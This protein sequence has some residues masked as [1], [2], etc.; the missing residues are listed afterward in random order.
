MESIDQAKHRRIVLRRLALGAVVWAAAWL[1]MVWLDG[2][3]DL[4]N[5]A[6]VLVLASASATLWLPVAVSLVAST[7]A[8]LAFNW[9]FVPPRGTLTVDLRQDALLLT[10][11]LVVSWIVA[12]IMALQRATAERSR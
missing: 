11:M 9:I 10:A 4:A 5:L 1:C 8:V 2:H 12:A 6:M 7:V 3:V